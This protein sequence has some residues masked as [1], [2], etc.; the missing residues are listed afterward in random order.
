MSSTT[1]TPELVERAA[2][3]DRAAFDA[4]VG[5]LKPQARGVVRR[6]IGHPEDSED[7]LQDALLKAW[8]GMKSFRQESQFSTWFLSIVTR[9]TIDFLRGQKRWRPEAQVAYANLCAQS[10]EMSGEVMAHFAAPDFAYEVREHISY[11]FSCVGRSLPP[12]EL[13]ALV[14]R[15]V[16]DMPAKDASAALGISDSVLRHRLAAARSAMQDRFAG[17]CTLVS[18]TGV[19]YQCEGLR[20]IA[21]ENRKGGPIPDL[22]DFQARCDVVRNCTSTSMQELHNLFWRRT[23]D[24]EDTGLGSVKPES[25]CGESG[26]VD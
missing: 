26:T 11:C 3:G 12:D 20:T 22:D 14:L 19:C 5:P 10:E 16:I 23:S 1:H 24:I 18:K 25:G 8:N 6:M 21:P 7:V 15:D 4:L 9:T 17:L 13:A 2:A